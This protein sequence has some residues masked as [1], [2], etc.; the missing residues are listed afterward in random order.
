[1]RD[2]IEAGLLSILILKQ[3]YKAPWL[4]EMR[5]RGREMARLNSVDSAK[6][7]LFEPLLSGKLNRLQL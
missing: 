4:H 7:P 5:A 2:L 3:V 6:R 1:M